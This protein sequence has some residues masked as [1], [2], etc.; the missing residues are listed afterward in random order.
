[1]GS[2]ACAYWRAYVGGGKE[3]RAMER[4]AC[5]NDTEQTENR[6]GEG[7]KG[8]GG[9]VGEGVRDWRS[10]G[11]AICDVSVEAGSH[12]REEQRERGSGMKAGCV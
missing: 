5:Q 3:C 4:H 2:R 1:M 12:W 7:G 9:R 6:E 11:S 8:K 10:S